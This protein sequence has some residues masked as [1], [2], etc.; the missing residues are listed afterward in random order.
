MTNDVKGIKLTNFFYSII[1]AFSFF[2]ILPVPKIEWTNRRLKHVPLFMP[3]VGFINGVL[4][5]LLFDLLS[6]I[7]ISR[8]GFAAAAITLI[9]HIRDIHITGVEL[10]DYHSTG[11]I[12]H[13]GGHSSHEP[14]PQASS[15]PGFTVYETYHPNNITISDIILKIIKAWPIKTVSI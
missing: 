9:G 15:E 5:Y 4:A 8:S 14:A 10:R 2:S 6:N 11:I 3:L 1:I 13:W 12:L 7:S